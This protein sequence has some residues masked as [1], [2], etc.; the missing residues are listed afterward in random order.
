MVQRLGHWTLNPVTRVQISVGPIF[1]VSYFLNPFPIFCFIIS[2][3][4][5][6]SSPLITI[7]HFP[8]SFSYFLFY[9]IILYFTYLSPYNHLPSYQVKVIPGFVLNDH[10]SC[11]ESFR[12]L[13]YHASTFLFF[14]KFSP[15]EVL[16]R[17]QVTHVFLLI[18]LYYFF[19][20]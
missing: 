13:L 19:G 17:I 11:K 20:I 15:F 14:V 1:F 5:S 7:F 10:L 9:Y 6:L 2:F 4:V 12:T 16:S 18:I 8:E 3:Y